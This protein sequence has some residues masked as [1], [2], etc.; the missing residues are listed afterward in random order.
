MDTVEVDGLHIAYERA[1]AGPAARPAPRLRGRRPDDVAAAARRALRR[2]HAGG[3]GRPGLGRLVRSARRVRHG[4]L[5]RLPGRVARRPP[6]RSTRTFSGCRSVASSGWPARPASHRRGG[7]HSGVRHAG[8]RGSCPRTSPRRGFN[9]PSCS[10][11]FRRPSSST[12]CF[13]R[14]SPRRR[15]RTRSRRSARA[16]SSSIRWLS[17]HGPCVRGEPPPRI[18]PGLHPTLLLYG[19]KD[20]RAGLSVARDLDAAISGARLVVLPGAGH[21]CN[22][23]AAGQVQRRRPDIPARHRHLTVVHGSTPRLLAHR[24]H[25]LAL[26]LAALG[27]P[28]CLAIALIPPA[29]GTSVRPS[30]QFERP[31]P[32]PPHG[33]VPAIG[34]DPPVSLCR[35]TAARRGSA[36]RRRPGWCR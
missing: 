28:V 26:H 24:H 12:R 13:R 21:V 7:A 35:I 18:A 30:V 32:L 25:D 19:E 8:W 5:R 2:V 27:I 1:G 22:I 11:F 15:R 23:E 34:A 29:V 36:R 10:P 14:C 9:R 17:R 6:A 33:A 3:L 4:R 31:G 16:C 20:V